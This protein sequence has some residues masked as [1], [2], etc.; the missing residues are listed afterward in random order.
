MDNRCPR[1]GSTSFSDGA[2]YDFEP[3][4]MCWTETVCDGCGLIGDVPWIN[5]SIDG[6]PHAEPYDSDNPEHAITTAADS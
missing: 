5:W 3:D 1:C 4:G 6:G 2:S